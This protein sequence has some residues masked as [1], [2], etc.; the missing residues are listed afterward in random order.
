MPDP[1]G[2]LLSRTDPIGTTTYSYKPLTAVNGAGQ[3][4]EENGPLADDTLRREYDWQG[5]QNSRQIRSDA[6]AVLQSESV[7]TDSLGR[8]TQTINELGTFTATYNPGNISPNM[9]TWSR[10]NGLATQFDWYAAGDGANALGLKEI[11]HVRSGATVSKFGYGYDLAG[12]IK[13]WS[14]QLDPAA[15]NK[16]DWAL[17]YSRA[18][19]LTGVVEKNASSVETNRASWSYDPSGNW[20]ATGNGTSTTHRTH[21][22]MNRLNQIGGLGKTVVEGTLNEPANVSVAGQ[23][24]QVSSLPGTSEFRFQKEMPVTEGNNNFQITATD[25]NGNARTQNYSVQVGS[26]QKTYEYD[27]NGNLLREKDPL[28]AIIRSFE[29][30]GADRL[31]AVNWGSQR[32]EWTYN[33][34][35]QRVLETVNG[36]AS[37]RFLWDGIALL[38]EKSPAGGITKRFYGDGEQRV[39]GTDSG[40]YYYTRD[41]LGSIR[42]V[43]NQPE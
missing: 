30:D 32:I 11:H 3:L 5:A 4:Y 34:L 15:A 39:G 27:P 22:S 25:A 13:N 23:P 43:V 2:R 8:L 21:D 29:W 7:L 36:V 31:K 16:K 10:P 6:G 38:L 17:A 42:E 9:N 18:G 1:F 37:K 28:G 26:A 24:A 41:H 40:N 33:G 12:R 35:G 14:R 19:E 20:Y